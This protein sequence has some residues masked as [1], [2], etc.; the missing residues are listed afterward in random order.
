MYKKEL[1]IMISDKAEIKVILLAVY[2]AFAIDIDEAVA[3]ES[4]LSS[5]EISAFDCQDCERELIEEGLLHMRVIDG[6]LCCGI[7]KLG[8][9]TYE[10]AKKLFREEVLDRIVSSVLR[11][12][13]YIC[14]GKKY[15]AEIFEGDGGYF[16]KCSLK[17]QNRT[18]M[19]TKF[20]FEKYE[21]ASSAL[22]NCRENPEMIFKGIETLMSGKINK[23]F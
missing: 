14:S 17:S 13:E 4:I 5:G 6:K 19:E 12:F 1:Y 21:E 16:V 23:M 15:E 11:H 10:Q 2:R 3:H 18:Y 9:G 8:A 7:T 22:Y 20:F